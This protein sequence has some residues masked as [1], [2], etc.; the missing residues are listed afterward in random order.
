[1]IYGFRFYKYI[2]K[3]EIVHKLELVQ[4][5]EDFM[6]QHIYICYILLDK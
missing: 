1:M 4:A 3:S 2:M 5:P 6:K